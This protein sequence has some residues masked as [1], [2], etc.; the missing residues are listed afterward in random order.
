[1]MLQ[2]LG[3]LWHNVICKYLMISGAQNVHL[4]TVNQV[5]EKH[6]SHFDCFGDNF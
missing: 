6:D 3:E 2:H 5:F 1:M 4:V